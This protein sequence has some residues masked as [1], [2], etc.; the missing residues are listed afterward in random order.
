[1][2]RIFHFCKNN[3]NHNCYVE[4]LLLEIFGTNG[5]DESHAGMNCL[6]LNLRV[7]RKAVHVSMCTVFDCSMLALF[8]NDIPADSVGNATFW[9][10]GLGLHPL[11]W[12]ALGRMCG[13][14]YGY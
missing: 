8:A 9:L 3:R 11:Q 10:V 1:M 4:T 2:F 7:M 13:N 12:C 6:P 14:D 5:K